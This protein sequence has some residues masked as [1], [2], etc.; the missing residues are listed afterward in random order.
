MYV[1]TDK[2]QQVFWWLLC[3]EFL[4]RNLSNTKKQLKQ[5]EYV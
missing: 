3:Y 2:D 4:L 1:Y 5:E